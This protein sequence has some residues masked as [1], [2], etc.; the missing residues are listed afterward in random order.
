[1]V[2]LS[3]KRLVILGAGGVL[4]LGIAAPAVAY[5]AVAAE[6]VRAWS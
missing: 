3:K 6:E 1:M 4:A 2:H 5:A